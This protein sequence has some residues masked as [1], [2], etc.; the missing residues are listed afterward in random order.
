MEGLIDP[1]IVSLVIAHFDTILEA[2]EKESLPVIQIY[3][4]I[5]EESQRIKEVMCHYF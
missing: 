5:N 1:D 4:A 3:D 2:V